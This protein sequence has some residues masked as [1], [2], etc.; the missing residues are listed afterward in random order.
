MSLYKKVINLVDSYTKEACFTFGKRYV[1]IKDVQ[2]CNEDNVGVLGL[3]AM[4]IK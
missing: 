4:P 3:K 2:I 1:K